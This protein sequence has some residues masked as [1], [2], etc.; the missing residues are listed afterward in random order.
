[1]ADDVRAKVAEHIL[2]HWPTPTSGCSCGQMRLGQSW[3]LHLAD[4]LLPLMIEAERARALTAV[5]DAIRY[6]TKWDIDW[7]HVTR[8]GAL[9]SLPLVR[10]SE[11]CPVCAELRCDD[12]CPL[13]PIRHQEPADG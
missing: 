4:E 9:D 12:D 10:T 3:P 8:A 5:R 7:C 6:T 11:V 2:E 1:M 13:R